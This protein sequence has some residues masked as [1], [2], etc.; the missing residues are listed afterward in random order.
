[1]PLGNL[2]AKKEKILNTVFAC[3][4]M[5][6]LLVFAGIPAMEQAQ[7]LKELTSSENMDNVP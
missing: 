7:A 3:L 5:L 6:T 4:L 1:M 2:K